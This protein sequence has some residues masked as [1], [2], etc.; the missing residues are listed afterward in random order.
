MSD[1]GGV[2]LPTGLSDGFAARTPDPQDVSDVTAVIA[3]CQLQ[4][5]GTVDIAEEDVRA[6]WKLPSFDLHRDAVVITLGGRIVAY[7]SQHH[8]RAEVAVHPDH[9][10]RGLGTALLEWTER[11]ARAAG[12][13]EVGQTVSERDG[14]ARELLQ[15]HGY[16]VRWDSWVFQ[17]RLPAPNPAPAPP[18][19]V[20][21]RPMR[22]PQDER[23]V[24]RV[25]EDAFGEW[26]GR[27]AVPFE[28]WVVALLDREDTDAGLTFV[29]HGEHDVVGAALCFVFDDEGWIQQLAVR[30]A[31]R[32]RGIGAALLAAAFAEFARRGLRTAGLSTDSRTGARALYERAG[33][34]VARS[35]AR[36]SKVL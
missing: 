22:R 16:A 19:G 33:M 3:A 11:H 21:V 2:T 29:A 1:G 12:A 36:Y 17:R 23:P 32:G 5:Y 28:D 8:G 18:P 25:I 6:D 26:A 30:A 35:Y 7:G 20:V 13:A 31:D 34:S 9:S 4:A 24:Y 27:A 15:R 10:R 14:A